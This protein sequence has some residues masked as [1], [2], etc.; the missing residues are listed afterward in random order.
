MRKSR[1]EEQLNFGVKGN[2]K[3][4]QIEQLKY[5]VISSKGGCEQVINARI[6]AA[7]NK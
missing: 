2:H 1:S 3:L 4:N 5:L 6:T 7:W